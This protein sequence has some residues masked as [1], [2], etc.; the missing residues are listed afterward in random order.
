MATNNGMQSVRNNR[1]LLRKRDTFNKLKG[2]IRRENSK[3]KM[4]VLSKSENRKIRLAL[5]EHRLA[6]DR[7]KNFANA[8]VVLIALPFTVL[9]FKFVQLFLF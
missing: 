6:S 4:K 5:D 9:I 2:M 1:A 7:G 8:I 3:G